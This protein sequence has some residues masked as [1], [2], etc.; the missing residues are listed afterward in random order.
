MR[1]S[2]RAGVVCQPGRRSS[3][4]A[5]HPQSFDVGG[6]LAFC[7]ECKQPIYLPVLDPT[8]GTLQ[9]ITIQVQGQLDWG[10]P[11]VSTASPGPLETVST[12]GSMSVFDDNGTVLGSE[13]ITGPSYQ[14]SFTDGVSGTFSFSA[15]GTLPVGDDS[16]YVNLSAIGY[17]TCT[18]CQVSYVDDV[19]GNFGGTLTTTFHYLPADP[20]PIPEPS[21]LWLLAVGLLGMVAA[22]H[23]RGYR[24]VR[25]LWGIIGPAGG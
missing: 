17:G 7:D 19:S 18:G 20:P 16:P 4:D 10:Q 8:L 1:R 2:G 23:R 15:S 5:Q 9:S 12:F 22:G 13:D 6:D 25:V 11:F 24:A 21:T 3:D 14:V